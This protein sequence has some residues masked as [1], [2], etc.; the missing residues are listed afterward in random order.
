MKGSGWV[1][2]ITMPVK[3]PEKATPDDIQQTIEELHNLF[4]NYDKV[5]LSVQGV[6]LCVVGLNN[7][8]RTFQI[9]ASEF[10]SPSE[11]L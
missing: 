5:E 9:R 7:S 3:N 6:L 8:G 1:E 4:Y 2:L 11:F 10:I